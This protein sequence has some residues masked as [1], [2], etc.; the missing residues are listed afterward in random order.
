MLDT[1]VRTPFA[2]EQGPFLSLGKIHKG[3]V[4]FKRATGS[5][6]LELPL[7][8]DVGRCGRDNSRWPLDPE[9]GRWSCN[10]WPRSCPSAGIRH[11]RCSDAV[12]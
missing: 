11:K 7:L 9:L 8:Q 1:W 10:I 2:G 4:I 3:I 5:T 6:R 12:T